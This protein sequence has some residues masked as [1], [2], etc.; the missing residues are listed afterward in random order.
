MISIIYL[1]T[2]NYLKICQR[3][4]LKYI[5]LNMKAKADLPI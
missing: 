3:L 2:E 5:N 1:H 4:M